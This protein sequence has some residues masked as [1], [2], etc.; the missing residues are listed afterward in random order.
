MNC[1]DG[2]AAPAAFT[3]YVSNQVA[4]VISGL[5][6]WAATKAPAS[7]TSNGVVA[8]EYTQPGGLTW[9]NDAFGNVQSWSL[10]VPPNF[11]G[12]DA[13]GQAL[14]LN[15][16]TNILK[17]RYDLYLVLNDGSFGVHNP[18]YARSLLSSAQ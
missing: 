6:R 17:A 7:L 8:W 10:S 3:P 18:P 13:S 12:P 4:S 9:T 5:N 2:Q 14:L 16:Y 11:T 1:H 15:N